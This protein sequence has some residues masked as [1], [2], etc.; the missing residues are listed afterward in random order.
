MI[1]TMVGVPSATVGFLAH[2]VIS[3][4]IGGGFAVLVGASGRRG[5][6]G[7]GL[8]YGVGW[9]MLGPLTLMP[10]F[11][12]MGFGVNWNI[13]AVTQAMPSLVGHLVFGG[14]LGATSHW[15]QYR[16]GARNAHGQATTA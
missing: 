14:I 1:G 4:T 7:S 5:G 9:W 13:T 16:V 8:G 10:L 3:A 2:M 6:V 12:G 11:M 15:L